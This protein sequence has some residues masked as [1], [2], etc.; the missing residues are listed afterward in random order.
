LKKPLG[1]FQNFYFFI[2]FFRFIHFHFFQ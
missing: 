1:N 2:N